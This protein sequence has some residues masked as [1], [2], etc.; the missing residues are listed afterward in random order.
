MV[1]CESALIYFNVEYVR[2]RVLRLLAARKEPV[3]LVVLYL[4]R[5]Q[6]STW[7]GLS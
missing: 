5:C 6:K 4:G 1:R 2:E 3:Q 7:P